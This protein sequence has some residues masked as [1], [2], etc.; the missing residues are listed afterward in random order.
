ML[1]LSLLNYFG[2][3]ITGS[4]IFGLR[5]PMENYSQTLEIISIYYIQKT[6]IFTI[7]TA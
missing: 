7:I 6:L 5:L 4:R 1:I 2:N 3:N